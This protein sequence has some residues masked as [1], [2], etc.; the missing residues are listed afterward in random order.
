MVSD[1]PWFKVDDQLFFNAKTVIAGNSAMGLWVRAG[2]WASANLTDGFVPTHMASAMANPMAN[3]CDHDALVEAGLW[4]VV[5]GGYQFHDWE[6]FQPSAAAEKERRKK[7]AEAGRLGAKARWDGKSDGK[8]HSKSHSKSHAEPMANECE[9]DAPSR[10]VPSLKNST[11]SDGYTDEFD[12]WWKLYPSTANKAGA[13]KAYKAAAKKHDDLDAK[14][15]HYLNA[16]S[17]QE[18]SGEFVPA[19]PNASTWLNQE[20]WNDYGEQTT[21]T[22]ASGSVVP[23]W[24]KAEC[25]EILGGSDYWVPGSPPA[26]LDIPGEMA[27][28]REQMEAHLNERRRKA[29][30]VTQRG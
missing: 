13:F 5:D 30:E 14:L 12:A 28:K 20:R 24:S 3:P 11:R 27:W 29:W 18:K 21:I 17:R 6:D 26:G 9:V 25:D 1:I 16:R 7:R 23:D 15:R 8:S 2:S 4:T 19:I 22:L 10:P